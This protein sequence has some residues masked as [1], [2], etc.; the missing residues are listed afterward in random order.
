MNIALII[1]NIEAVYSNIEITGSRKL[2]LNKKIP[3]LLRSELNGTVIKKITAEEIAEDI[4]ILK[5]RDKFII[6]KTDEESLVKT[7]PK[8]TRPNK[9]TR[10]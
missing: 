8:K 4:D 7:P 1:S 9:I 2:V 10:K 3:V 6:D 5:T